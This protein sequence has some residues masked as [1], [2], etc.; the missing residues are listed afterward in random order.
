MLWQVGVEMI[1]M[2]PWI[3]SVV[4]LPI[5]VLCSKKNTDDTVYDRIQQYLPMLLP[6]P[7]SQAMSYINQCMHDHI[8]E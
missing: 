5:S 2:T 6:V 3:H 7:Q 4:A 8:P 1:V